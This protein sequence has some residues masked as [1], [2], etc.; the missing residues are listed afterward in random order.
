MKRVIIIST[1]VFCFPLIAIAVP[2]SIDYQ[3]MLTSPDGTLIDTTVDIT[4]RIYP[5]SWSVTP[6][7]DEIH[8]VTTL[9]GLYD[10][11]LGLADPLPQNFFDDAS[12]W[13]GVQV[14]T[15]MEMT[16]R[17]SFTSVPY[18][19]RIGTVDEAMGGTI[20]GYLTVGAE[21]N[22]VGDYSNVFGRNNSAESGYAVI[23]GGRYNTA[24][25]YLSV[26]A[27]GR[28][29]SATHERTVV[30]GG[31]DNVASGD[32]ATVG[33]G[34]NNRARGGFSVIAGGGGPVAADSN[35]ASGAS[36][37]I[38][39]G[40][41]NTASAQSST[42]SGGYNNTADAYY[43][44]IGG[45]SYHSAS[46]NYSTV[47]GGYDNEVSGNNS[48][49][50]GGR[51]NYATLDDATVG[52]GSNNVAGDYYATVSGGG[53][54][55]ALGE[56]SVIAG[57]GGDD[58]T[59]SN[60]AQGNLSVIGGGYHNYAT[61]D[62]STIAGG[63]YHTASGGSATIGGGYRNTS[64]SFYS[65][66]GGGTYNDATGQYATI[67]GGSNNAAQGNYSFAAGRRAKAL[68]SGCFRWADGTNADFTGGE[69]ADTT[70]SFAVRSS[71][72][73]VFYTNTALTSGTKLHS[74]SSA[75]SSAS[76]SC[77]KRNARAVD[78][79]DVLNRV[80]QLPIKQWSYKAQDPSI[81]HIGPMAQDFWKLFH[82]GDDS[83]SIST[84]DPSGI[85]LAAIQELAKQITELRTEVA[86]L[87]A[88][89]ELL[90][91]HASR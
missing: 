5:E 79:Q 91:K 1:F 59:E 53:F 17:M 15:D 25:G 7:W 29:N 42:I 54:N 74:G 16:P 84:I 33:G 11:T 8:T 57:G 78:T 40:A 73:V 45:G 14:G 35:S 50:S 85:A 60:S 77:K 47:S 82:V 12:M 61:G 56:F 64:T 34:Q 71:H 20:S 37:F 83:L 66:V 38:G 13:L 26:I 27:G 44:T 51:H 31:E 10:A 81:E 68:A 9:N 76:D 89:N 48:T 46:G 4:F 22:N 24:S 69:F 39:G 43:A 62:A 88:Q 87:R 32:H 80:S 2:S 21:N 90:T 63:Y 41:Q 58:T 36:A 23:G 18:A 86:T 75:W 52:G 19:Y 70:N 28:N 49:V 72:G 67:P 6:I 30:S 55:Y 65:T 3:G